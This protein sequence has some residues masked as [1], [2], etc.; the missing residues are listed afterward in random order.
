MKLNE[1][2]LPQPLWASQ[3]SFGARAHQAS[4][5]LTESGVSESQ[6][7]VDAGQSKEHAPR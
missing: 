3:A 4:N 7:K 5:S 1:G 6:H 2:T